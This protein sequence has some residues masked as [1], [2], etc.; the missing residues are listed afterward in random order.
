M[1]IVGRRTAI[2]TS[3]RRGRKPVI[4][5][6]AG[7]LLDSGSSVNRAREWELSGYRPKASRVF[8]ARAE[9]RMSDHFGVIQGNFVGR[10]CS[11]E[12]RQAAAR[13][14]ESF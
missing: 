12:A 10:S 14:D 13:Y 6:L 8:R 2:E 5:L 7:S 9:T 4:I 11:S 3:T 1:K